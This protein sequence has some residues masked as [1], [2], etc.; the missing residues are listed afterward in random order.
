M[1]SR[2]RSAT[3]Q[4]SKIRMREELRAKLDRD[5]EARNIS[6]NAA[7]VSRLERSF[8]E[9]ETTEKEVREGQIP[10]SLA[11]SVMFHHAGKEAAGHDL[12]EPADWTADPW[13]FEQGALAAAVTLWQLHPDPR[14]GGFRYWLSRLYGQVGQKLGMKPADASPV[15]V[16]AI[17]LVGAR[18]LEDM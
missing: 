3:V 1:R 14:P 4:L 7:I 11:M 12:T 16:S 18:A 2:D 17:D 5:A 13:C 8:L 15:A 10:I 9:E 6:L